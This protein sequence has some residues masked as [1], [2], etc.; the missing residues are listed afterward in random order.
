MIRR[1]FVI[2]VSL[3]AFIIP[4][5]V[6]VGTWFLAAGLDPVIRSLLSIAGWV[7]AFGL[8]T[9]LFWGIVVRAFPGEVR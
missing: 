2:L 9:R 1:L 3:V 6:G 8:S 7:V 4:N 5:A